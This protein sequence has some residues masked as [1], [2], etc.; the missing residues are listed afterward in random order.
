MF[1]VLLLY[2]TCLCV[3][4]LSSDAHYCYGDRTFHIRRLL[5]ERPRLLTLSV[6]HFARRQL[7]S[8]GTIPDC[9]VLINDRL[10]LS[11]CMTES[12]TNLYNV[13]AY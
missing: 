4:T 7:I 10:A 9:L 12:I 3:K 5:T 1:Y 8:T 2:L 13:I 6:E 11:L